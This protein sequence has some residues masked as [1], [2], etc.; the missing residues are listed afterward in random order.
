M[1]TLRYSLNI[2]APR[3]KISIRHSG[4]FSP[5]FLRNMPFFLSSI[6]KIPLYKIYEDIIKW[7][8]SGAK[9]SFYCKWT[10]LET[11]VDPFSIIKISVET[12]GACDTK[13]NTGSLG[14]DIKGS[15]E[16]VMEYKTPFDKAFKEQYIKT[17]YNKR[18][19]ELRKIGKF[20]IETIE[21]EIK[22]AL[23]VEV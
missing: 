8:V 5:S 1:G 7:D 4:R 2:L 12:A 19:A 6:L 23:G 13:E 17:L 22:K 10:I 11:E 21:R 16:T 14:I 18:R 9:A 20:Y 15:I 3:P